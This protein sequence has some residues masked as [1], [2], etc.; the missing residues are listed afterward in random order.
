MSAPLRLRNHG[1]PR[2]A[3]NLTMLFTETGFM[4]RFGAAAKSGFAAVECQLPYDYEITACPDS[5]PTSRC[6]SPRPGSWTVSAPRRS[7]GSQRLNVSSLTITKSRHAQIRRQ[8]HDAVHRDRVH[9]P[10]RRRGEV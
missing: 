1:M 10:F 4:D 5:P 3:A 8:P 7:P 6:C 9:G 2:F